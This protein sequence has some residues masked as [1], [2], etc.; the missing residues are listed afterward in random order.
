MLDI[1]LG[2]VPKE[3]W[4][5]QETA[6]HA[7]RLL[8]VSN[9]SSAIDEYLIITEECKVDTSD[10]R[11]GNV[12]LRARKTVELL[13]LE[14]RALAVEWLVGRADLRGHRPGE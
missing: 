11:D 10:D 4:K 12:E 1:D 5:R 13:H 3:R 9:Y 8:A 14:R 7:L 2:K 6:Q